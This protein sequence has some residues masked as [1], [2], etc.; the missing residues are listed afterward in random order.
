MTFVGVDTLPVWLATLVRQLKEG[1]AQA[2]PQQLSPVTALKELLVV[3]GAMIVGHGAPYPDD[4]T[5]LK[6]DLLHSFDALGPAS[7]ARHRTA[8]GDSRQ[9]AARLKDLLDDV[10]GAH[11]L[12]AAADVLLAELASS[13]SRVAAFADCVQ[14]F[15]EGE[16]VG[17][18]DT[19]LRYLR[20]VV[21]AAGHEVRARPPP[22]SGARRR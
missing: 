8:S 2:P 7:T 16:F 19:R 9:L 21:E 20:T 10:A 4:R 14:A 11:V 22:A 18:C 17:V 12:H 15:R 5:S 1:G 3:T 6:D 13:A